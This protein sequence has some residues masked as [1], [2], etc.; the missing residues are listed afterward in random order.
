[1]INTF[2]MPFSMALG[3]IDTKTLL[4]NVM[5]IPGVLVGLFTGR[6]LIQR[7]SQ[8][9]FD[10]LLLTF[11]AMAALRLIGLFYADRRV[12]AQ[13]VYDLR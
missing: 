9:L 13:P 7:V 6:W 8:R 12:R 11:A 2:K 5:L 1:M 3:L 4:L 10:A